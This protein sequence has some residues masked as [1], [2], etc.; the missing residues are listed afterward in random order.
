MR[1]PGRVGATP[2]QK[3]LQCLLPLP[4]WCWQCSVWAVMGPGSRE[5]RALTHMPPIPEGLPEHGGQMCICAFTVL[6]QGQTW[7]VGLP[8]VPGKGPRCPC[9]C[10]G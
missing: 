10:L 7:N 1:G 4:V 2:G 8:G 3:R 9:G 5:P 6:F